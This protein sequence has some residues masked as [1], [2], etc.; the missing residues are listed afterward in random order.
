MPFNRINGFYIGNGFYQESKTMTLEDRNDEVN[1]ALETRF[2]QLNAAFEAH[3]AK[4]KAM[5]VPRDVSVVYKQYAD[6]PDNP[7]GEYKFFIGL[8]KLGG[9]WRLCYGSCHESWIG[10]DDEG[11]DWKPI[12]DSS[13][14]ERMEAA[15]H[16]DKLR[17]AIVMAKEKLVPVVE[18]AIATLAKSLDDYGKDNAS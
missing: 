9:K 11:I 12:V 18:N 3:E 5:M 6:H 2:S 7:G 1:K 15:E 4:L 17:E 8:I 14:E 10:D 13:L 16:L